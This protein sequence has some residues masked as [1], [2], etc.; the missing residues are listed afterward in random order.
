MKLELAK[1]LDK[2]MLWGVLRRPEEIGVTVQYCSPSMIIP[3]SEPGEY[4]LVTDFSSFNKHKHKK[5][6]RYISHYPGSQRVNSPC[7]ICSSA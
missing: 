4:R 2:L 3:K 6:S 1:K 5:V 7:P